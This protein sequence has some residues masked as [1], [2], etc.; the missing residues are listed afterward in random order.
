MN[1]I[2]MSLSAAALIA[3]ITILRALLL[4]KLPKKTFMVL[5]WLVLLRLLVPVSIPSDFSIYSWTARI[6]A[7]PPAAGVRDFPIPRV[8]GVSNTAKN[9]IE[10]AAPAEAPSA[11]E[12][13]PV[14]PRSIVWGVGFV[15]SGGFFLTA[16]LRMARRFRT[17]SPIRADG[18]IRDWLERHPLRRGLSIRRSGFISAPLSYGLVRPVI[19]LPESSERE[20]PRS[21]NY[22]LT[23]EY[24][25]IRRF[26]ILSK[27]AMILA[28]CIHWFNPLAWVMFLLFN[29]DIELACDETVLKIFGEK[30]KSAYAHVLIEMATQKNWLTP[31]CNHFNK[32]GIEERIVAIMKTGKKSF[33]TVVFAM[34]LV[35][36]FAV[37][38]ATSAEDK[39]GAVLPGAENAREYQPER[40]YDPRDQA[41]A[42][43]GELSPT[44]AESEPE[45]DLRPETDFSAE[46]FE[47]LRAL[48]FAGYE[49]MTVAEFQAQVWTATDTPAY[50]DLLERFSRSESFYALKDGDSD[51]SFLF[52]VLE[53]LTA[54]NWRSRKFDGYFVRT[55]PPFPDSAMFEFSYTLEIRDAETLTVRDY[56]AARIGAADALNNVLPNRTPDQLA[57]SAFMRETIRA[58][59]EKIKERYDSDRLL[60][61][62]AYSYRPLSG[63]DA[64][65]AA[66][67]AGDQTREKRRTPNASREDYRSLLRLKTPGYQDMRLA[68]FNRKL[69]SWTNEDDERTERI[70]EDISGN[71]FAVPLSDDELSF[72]KRTV[73]LSGLENAETVKAI[74]NNAPVGQVVVSV[75]LPA[76]TDE[77]ALQGDSYREFALFYQF[78]YRISSEDSITVAERDRSVENVI[79][80]IARFWN[81]SSAAVL[82]ATSER[83]LFLKLSAA[84]AESGDE[85]ISF[86]LIEDQFRFEKPEGQRE[87]RFL[88]ALRISVDSAA[89]DFLP[90]GADEGLRANYDPEVYT[91]EIDERNGSASVQIVSKTGDNLA[92]PVKLYIP[93]QYVDSILLDVSNASVE[94]A[95]VF[96]RSS[97]VAV[98]ENSNIDFRRPFKGYLDAELIASIVNFSAAT[99]YRGAEIELMA[100]NG[101]AGI[102]D[103]FEKDGD[104]YVY[105]GGAG[106]GRIALTLDGDSVATFE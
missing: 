26:D 34:L 76:K 84:I 3:A 105:F 14:S 59:I 36:G 56:S 71:D 40:S 37:V 103:F 73:Y 87:E 79:S 1:L 63:A 44:D 78:S 83:E 32:N 7:E 15:L 91:V 42:T 47:T 33:L 75:D 12:R 41:G 96:S 5:W 20:D 31:L 28:L 60:I 93:D 30:N 80:E 10:T 55:V 4:H 98:F 65:T 85:K 106:G 8:P 54:E 2:Q 29:R 57:D 11:P 90:A 45:N 39:S 70:N 97:V 16:Y 9:M 51:A 43:V 62:V 72:L 64:G 17:A 101:I 19:L 88:P 74:Y 27:A 69:L 23:H 82:S 92:E 38:F 21:L 99:A 52:Y 25:H 67:P 89:A 18:F 66:E 22:V 61:S 94:I 49:S 46:D 95:D 50:Q 86:A 81:D 13:A 48:K 53:P 35:G 104:R 77:S 24:V 102:P 100:R 6:G 58:E 68:E